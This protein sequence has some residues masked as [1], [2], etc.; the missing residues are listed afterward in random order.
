MPLVKFIIGKGNYAKVELEFL[1]VSNGLAHIPL[2][3]F[4]SYK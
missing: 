1:P 4:Q 3:A 2:D